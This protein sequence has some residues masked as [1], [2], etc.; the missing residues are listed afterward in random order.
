MCSEFSS[1]FSVIHVISSCTVTVLSVCPL[2]QD[3]L[4]TRKILN[5]S[6]DSC[7][8]QAGLL[9]QS[10]GQLQPPMLMNSIYERSVGE[11]WLV[12]LLS[13]AWSKTSAKFSDQISFKIDILDFHE[14]FSAINYSQ[15]VLKISLNPETLTLLFFHLK[16]D[17]NTVIQYS[18][19]F[20][21][22][23]SFHHRAFYPTHITPAVFE[24][25]L[26]WCCCQM[27][28][29][30][31]VAVW[32]WECVNKTNTVS[33]SYKLVHTFSLYSTSKDSLT[34]SVSRAACSTRRRIRA[35]LRFLSCKTS[36]CVACHV[37]HPISW[38]WK[39][40]PSSSRI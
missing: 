3:F 10:D 17:R 5:R 27:L 25:L 22:G 39:R 31:S 19:I 37:D 33:V 12:S 36:V 8:G 1:S 2:F 32:C 35:H 24:S 20:S 9:S 13:T 6:F 7:V 14:C 4:D 11:W 16:W 38:T 29:C 34:A 18:I 21:A 40:G 23:V 28:I 30:L 15:K 26:L